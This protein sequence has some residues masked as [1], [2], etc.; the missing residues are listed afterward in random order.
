MSVVNFSRLSSK[1][2]F[3]TYLI[4]FM[5]L[6]SDEFERLFLSILPVSPLSHQLSLCNSISLTLSFFLSY[7]V[8]LSRI[9]TFSFTQS[10][11]SHLFS[12]FQCSILPYLSM[13]IYNSLFICN[14]VG[15]F[16]YCISSSPSSIFSLLPPPFFLSLSVSLGL[17]VSLSLSLFLSLSLY[18]S[19]SHMIYHFVYIYFTL[20]LYPS[21]LISFYFP[22]YCP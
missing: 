12:H 1:C 5:P 18:L 2:K 9:L 4:E 21:H 15:Q 20:S 14:C 16:L 13:L 7:C 19:L 6:L 22:L 8:Y 10:F 11:S 17:S 3:Y